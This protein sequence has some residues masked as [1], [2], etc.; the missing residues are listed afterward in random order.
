MNNRVYTI[1]EED[2]SERIDK[3]L[4]AECDDLSRAYLQKIIEKGNVLVNDKVVKSNYKLRLNDLVLLS[5]DEPEELDIPAEDIPLD[6]IYED[7]DVILINKPKG[8]VVHPA[9]G[10]FTGTLVNALLFHCKDSLS[11][12]NGV[13]RPGIVHRIDMDTTGVIAVC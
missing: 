1:S 9:A 4:T 10:H 3:F 13:L 6:I 5:I 12:I 7:D 8:M 2:V 11:S